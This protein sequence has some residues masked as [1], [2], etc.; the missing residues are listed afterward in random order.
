MG[1]SGAI[2]STDVRIFRVGVCIYLCVSKSLWIQDLV[3]ILF[4]FVFLAYLSGVY[5]S[6]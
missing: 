4:F 1:V 2:S 3:N 6:K 5:I